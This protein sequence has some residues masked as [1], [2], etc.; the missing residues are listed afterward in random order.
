MKSMFGN[1]LARHFSVPSAPSLAL[2]SP[3]QTL[4]AMTRVTMPDGFPAPRPVSG[5]RKHFL[6]RFT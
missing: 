5:R 4:M 2:K 3:T 1:T 6:F